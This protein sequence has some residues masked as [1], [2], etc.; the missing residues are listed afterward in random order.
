VTVD[1]SDPPDATDDVPPAIDVNTTTPTL[2]DVLANDSDPDGGP[3][4][5]TSVT[6]PDN[7]TVAI[8][9]DFSAVTYLADPG[10]CNTPSSPT[11]DF[12]YTVNGIATA[13]VFMTVTCAAEPPPATTTTPQQLV[14]TPPATKK[15]KKGFK[16]VRGKC[17][18][19][20]RKRKS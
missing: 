2:I 5:I 12:T 13:T 1:C 3:M 17:K 19:K 9:D 16:K 10:Y 4:G 18:K 11:D 8:L 7:G 6:E 20:K 15:C 14:P